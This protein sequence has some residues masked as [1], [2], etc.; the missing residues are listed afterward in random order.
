[1]HFGTSK[2]IF[3]LSLFPYRKASSDDL[4]N[5]ADFFLDRDKPISTN[6]TLR[7][8]LQRTWGLQK[9]PQDTDE[10]EHQ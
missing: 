1:M 8:S 10:Y 7:V 6:A 2:P 9:S 4:T 3:E 5:L